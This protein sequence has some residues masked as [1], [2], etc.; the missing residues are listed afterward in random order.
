MA[1]AAAGKSGAG[2]GG[3]KQSAVRKGG[4][5]AR[6]GGGGGGGGGTKKAP[7]LSPL[8]KE[9]RKR[10]GFQ[11]PEQEA[12]LNVL[13]TAS[14]LGEHIFTI[15]KSHGLSDATYNALRILR[16]GGE[17]ERGVEGRNCSQIAADMVTRVPDVTRIVDRL[18]QTGLAARFRVTGDRRLVMVKITRAGLD[19]LAKLDEPIVRAHKEQLGH[20][21]RA[22]LDQLSAI[23]VKARQRANDDGEVE[24]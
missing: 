21:T 10:A 8:A 24:A 5:G 17:G 22:E 16:G 3:G 15:L 23:L 13:R 4:G 19:V 11:S 14:V 7:A 6:K 20:L 12:Y 2:A 18:E 9:L 1:R